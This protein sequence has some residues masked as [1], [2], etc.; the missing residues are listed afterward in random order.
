MDEEPLY[1]LR[2]VSYAGAGFAGFELTVLGIGR[3]GW[4]FRTG[5]G[6]F[7]RVTKRA[8]LIVGF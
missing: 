5:G 3:G 7:S 2:R 1:A 6:A 8:T 4:F